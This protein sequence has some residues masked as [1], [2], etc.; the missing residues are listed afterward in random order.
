MCEGTVGVGEVEVGSL[1]DRIHSKIKGN[2][3][4]KGLIRIPV[5]PQTFIQDDQKSLCT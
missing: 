2:L 4:I 1:Q 5:W 3:E